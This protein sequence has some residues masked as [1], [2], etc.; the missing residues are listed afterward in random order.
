VAPGQVDDPAAA[1]AVIRRTT[2]LTHGLTTEAV[3]LTTHGATTP[4]GCSWMTNW[5][6]GSSGT[7]KAGRLRPPG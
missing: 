1:V 5:G 7:P 4:A 6:P 2:T 3:V